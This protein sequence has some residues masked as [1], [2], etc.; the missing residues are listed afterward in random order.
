MPELPDFPDHLQP[1]LP[2]I[3]N[4]YNVIEITCT[5]DK[6]EELQN[7]VVAAV[8]KLIEGDF[9]GGDHLLSQVGQEVNRIINQK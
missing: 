6:V 8:H 7:I 1:H 3:R 4:L 5:G 2:S 9:H